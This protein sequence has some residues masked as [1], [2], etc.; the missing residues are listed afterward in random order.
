MSAQNKA[1]A[2]R[3]FEAFNARD[4]DAFD[5][6]LAPDAVDH[7]PQNP[8][9]EM[10]GPE[11]AKRNAQMYHAAFSD[12]RF[13]VHEQLAEGDCVVTRWTAKGTNDGEL[14]GMSPTGKSVEIDG[15][16]IDRIA[17]GKVVESWGCWDTLGM[18][19]QLGVVPE[20]QP[21]GA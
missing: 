18:M 15:I 5:E 12:G 3:F 8:F 4:L 17:D 11:G 14:M 20:A 9:R 1:V 19:Q 7:D 21:A 2:M 16:G 13:E 10:R 6:I